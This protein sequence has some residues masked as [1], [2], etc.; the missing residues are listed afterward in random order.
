M[1][2]LESDT[3][4]S[5]LFETSDKEFEAFGVRLG[6]L[7]DEKSEYKFIEET[8]FEIDKVFLTQYPF[9][10]D[11]SESLARYKNSSEHKSAVNLL[12]KKNLISFFSP[13][14]I[15]VKTL[16]AFNRFSNLG[17]NEKNI[18]TAEENKSV[19]IILKGCF[20]ETHLFCLRII[21]CLA[22]GIDDNG[23]FHYLD[24]NLSY[25]FCQKDEVF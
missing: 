2:F 14:E 15:A 13:E 25:G 18:F 12:L 4:K 7:E 3:F 20:G 24:C 1:T 10:F 21:E 5:I 23:N 17:I 11:S 6:F 16:E 22:A 9:S 19:D 8:G